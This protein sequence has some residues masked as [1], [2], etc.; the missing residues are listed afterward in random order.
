M[1]IHAAF[2][3]ATKLSAL[4]YLIFL[5]DYLTA[6]IFVNDGPYFFIPKVIT[7]G[8]YSISE[9]ALELP[10]LNY[11]LALAASLPA[12][13]GCQIKTHGVGA[14]DDYFLRLVQFFVAAELEEAHLRRRL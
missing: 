4:D 13:L 10:D 12:D 14:L 6:P 8:D 1:K 3:S 5:V 7:F 11:C 2:I 9:L